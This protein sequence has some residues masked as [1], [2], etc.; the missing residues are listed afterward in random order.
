[1]F[2][3]TGFFSASAACLA[4]SAATA[5]AS[6]LGAGLAAGLTPGLSGTFADLG[7]GL[8]FSVPF[9]AE[10][11]LACW[12]RGRL[13]AVFRTGL[14]FADFL[15]ALTATRSIPVRACRRSAGTP[16]APPYV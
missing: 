5:L 1:G 2:T 10:A 12:V 9:L 15:V 8:T 13:A 3:G 16:I 14:A 4:F 7:W 6:S 11:A